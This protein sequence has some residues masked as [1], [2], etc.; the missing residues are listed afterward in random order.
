LNGLEI[1][2]RTLSATR[3]PDKFGNHWQYHSRSDHHSKVAC[4][5]ILFDMLQTS[6]ILK[7]H[8]S[9]GA[10]VFGLNHQMRDFKNNRKKDLDLVVSRPRDGA[11]SGRAFTDLVS[12][13]EIQLT[14]EE[15]GGLSTLPVFREGPVG[16]V[17]MALEAKACMTEHVKALPRLYD[18]LNSSQQTIHG[19]ADEAVAVGF[20]MVNAATSFLS[21]GKNRFDTRK[22]K[23]DV[24]IHSQTGVTEKVV[25]KLHEM[26]RRSKT[27]ESGFDALG[28]AVVDCKND[29]SPVELVTSRPAPLPGD[30]YNYES[31]IRRAAQL[32]ETRFR[33]V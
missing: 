10:V 7:E 12:I 27:G 30:I 24:S 20:V 23:P 26:G 3:I 8:V 31:M 14:P 6:A 29:G 28:I 4:W 5:A 19:A 32:Y 2:T 13:Y 18:E 22:V 9:H 21:P 11:Q 15:R 16:S 25:E 33:T 1:L 17:Q